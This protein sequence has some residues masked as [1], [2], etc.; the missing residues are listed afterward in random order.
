M[1]SPGEGS[2][3]SSN[4]LLAGATGTA[5]AGLGAGGGAE[6][7]AGGAG[8]IVGLTP[9]AIRAPGLSAVVKTLLL[10]AVKAV[11]PEPPASVIRL[12]IAGLIVWSAIRIP[13]VLIAPSGRDVQRHENVCVLIL[14]AGRVELRSLAFGRGRAADHALAQ[15]PCVFCG[16][17]VSPNPRGF[18]SRQDGAQ[19]AQMIGSGAL[20]LRGLAFLRT[21]E[22]RRRQQFE[23]A[24]D[25]LV[26]G[27]S[28]HAR[29]RV[30]EDDA[31]ASQTAGRTAT[32]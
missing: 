5:G 3:R 15:Y 12:I 28:D 31:V 23:R 4:G 10:S 2:G 26:P 11:G 21:G 20:G 8:V 16:V 17:H 22:F 13:S 9:P 19:T 32:R 30:T 24:G 25:A 27:H 29:G 18:E 7:G 14:Q 1:R 6:A